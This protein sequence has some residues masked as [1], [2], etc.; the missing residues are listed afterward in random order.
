M[1]LS[2][3]L[4]SLRCLGL[5]LGLLASGCG[6]EVTPPPTLPVG[7]P[8]KLSELTW[9]G[10]KL[11]LG[12]IT[13]VAEI[14][15]DSYFSGGGAGYSDYLAEGEMLKQRGRMYAGTKPGKSKQW[16]GLYASRLRPMPVCPSTSLR[17]GPCFC[18]YSCA[19]ARI[20]FP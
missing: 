14:Y 11:D 17:A 19:R 9:N 7:E 12:R 5:T 3:S 4:A 13:A 10:R 6:D 15:D 1:V 20:L 8:F 18:S 2:R 16:P